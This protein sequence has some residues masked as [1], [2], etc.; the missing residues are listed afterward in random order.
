MYK[1]FFKSAIAG[2]L[3][4]VTSFTFTVFANKQSGEDG[5]SKIKQRGS[6]I[7]GFDNTF[8]PMGY[9]DKK[10]NIV[11]FDIDLAKE[12]AKKM[13]LKVKFQPIDWSMKETELKNKNIDAIWNGYSITKERQ[14]KVAFTK[15]Y[16]KNRQ[17][18]IVLAGS[19]IKNKASLKAKKVAAQTG[20]SSVDAVKKDSKF[21][22]SVDGGKL[23][24][25]ETNNDAL[26]DLEAKRV[27]AVVADEILARYYM[28]Q[29]GKSKY[30]VLKE[31]FGDETYGVGV[32]MSDKK[33]LQSLQ[34]ALDAMKK[35]GISAKISKKW[36]GSDIVQ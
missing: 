21:L 22:K 28:N 33:F 29:R 32:R 4:L 10:G 5:F 14:Q 15:P 7:V 13:G 25:F 36:F 27:D 17:V 35:D 16:L 24:T 11:G 12:A 30:K 6:F 2:I 31:N 9:K 18:I 8:L 26:M 3:V 23:V 20:S 34:K 19:N 1:K